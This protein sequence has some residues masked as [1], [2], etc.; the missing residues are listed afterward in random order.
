M[1]PWVGLGRGAPASPGRLVHTCCPVCVC[2]SVC[3]CVLS[4]VMITNVLWSVGK[5][6]GPETGQLGCDLKPEGP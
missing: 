2:V 4:H 5:G 6:V 1:G 3:V